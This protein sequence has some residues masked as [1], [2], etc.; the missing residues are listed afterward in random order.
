MLSDID[1]L[2]RRDSQFSEF[3]PDTAEDDENRRLLAEECR[4]LVIGAGGLGC[5]LLKNL[6]LSG[7]KMIE[8]ID[9]DVV[10]VSN[11]NRQFLFRQEDIGQPKAIVAADFV[12]SRMKDVRIV[13][14]FKDITEMSLDFYQQFNLI[15]AG[16]DS[17]KAR[18]WINSVLIGITEKGED[19]EWDPS[20]II[21]L[22][23]GGTEGFKG[24]V[25]V[26]IPRL[27]S[28]I[29][30]SIDLYP[31]DPLN[32]PICTL[33][34]RPRQPEHCIQYVM[35]KWDSFEAWKGVKFD[36][37]NSE[38]MAWVYKMAK[39]RAQQFGISGVTLKL[40]QGVI[41]RIIPAVA[42]TNAIIAASCVNEAFKF[43]THASR[44]L[45]NYMSY[46]GLEG[47]YTNVF[48]YKKKATCPVCGSEP[49]RMKVDPLKTLDS[50]I[51][52]LVADPSLHLSAPSLS[53]GNKPR[54]W[55]YI[56]GA[57]EEKTAP[58]LSKPLRDLV[59]EGQTVYITD[60]NLAGELLIQI[61]VTFK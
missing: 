4:I 30:C 46:N 58:N 14:H 9:M 56:R 19:G 23:D 54:K 21:P 1:Y 20:T 61:L 50:F 27:T 49:I 6:A 40:T 59:E 53:A 2:L 33:T 22:I 31:I 35:L 24:Q 28:C 15:I 45:N 34:E 42:S 48:E 25:R 32:F 60:P 36:K 3:K 55:L 8:V 38:H 26:I 37:D 17:I 52:D 57:L 10:D 13:P 41:K 7:F 5:E 12:N 11:L 29:E 18:R 47:V 51:Q 43:A 44:Y 39:E 16:L